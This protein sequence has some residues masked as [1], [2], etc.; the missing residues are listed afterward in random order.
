MDEK[1][2]LL[3]VPAQASFARSVRMTASAL[4]VAAGIE[5]IEDVEDVKMIA[6]EGFVYACATG[7]EDVEVAF[8]LGAGR[9]GMDFSLGGARPT[10]DSVELVRVLLL[11]L[12]DE[13]DLSEDGATLHLVRATGGSD[14]E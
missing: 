1:H 6:D 7:P 3:R 4:A 14:D 2:V 10:D 11:A 8:T 5:S 12:C 13:F 9:M